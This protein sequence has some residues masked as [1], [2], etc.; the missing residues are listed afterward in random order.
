MSIIIYKSEIEDGLEQ[1]IQANA[2]IAYTSIAESVSESLLEKIAASVPKLKH[3]DLSKATNENQLDLHYLTTLMV[4][5][6]WNLNDDVFMPEEVWPA[7]HTPED[8]PFNYEHN[9]ADIIGHITSNFAIDDDSKIIKDDVPFDSLPEYFHIATSTVL[10]KFWEDET[11]A[12]RMQDIIVDI[13]KSKWFVSMEALFNGFDYA[14][15]SAENES[16]I[17]ARNEKSAFLTKH[18]R[19]Y[20]GSGQY[21]D[22]KVGRLLRHITFSGKGLVRKPANPKSIIFDDVNTFANASLITTSDINF[23]SKTNSGYNETTE[24]NKREISSMPPSEVELLQKQ[25]SEIKDTVVAIKKERDELQTQLTAL[26]QTAI[27]AK[28]DGLK[29]NIQTRDETIADLEEKGKSQEDTIKELEAK[30]KSAEETA[31]SVQTEL[32]K[33]KAETIKAHRTNQL[34]EAGF[35]GDEL[36]QALSLTESMD[37]EQFASFISLS[38]KHLDDSGHDEDEDERKKKKKKVKS[39]EDETDENTDVNLD[40]VDENVDADLNVNASSD[41]DKVETTRAQIVAYMTQTV[42]ETDDSE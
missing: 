24:K 34:T 14:I 29:Q 25:L 23:D 17:I 38:K 11:L 37:D 40:D 28:I 36:E 42:P 1:Q 4:S 5:T 20:G 39:G 41:D 7:R 33:I 3:L 2:S 6:G 18:L 8:K 30:V 35:E 9:Q 32:D 27:T 31:T 15:I 22:C 26:D 10:Y 12:K 13:A 21:N 16:R 19:A